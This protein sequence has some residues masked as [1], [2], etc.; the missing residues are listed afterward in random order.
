MASIS[1]YPTTGADC[2]ESFHNF[3]RKIIDSAKGIACDEL[4]VEHFE[5]INGKTS[6]HSL[7]IGK[8]DGAS[9]LWWN[10]SNYPNKKF[11]FP[12]GNHKGKVEVWFVKAQN[13]E[14]FTCG[15]LF[16]SYTPTD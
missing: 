7:V 1:R 11:T 15:D 2:R 3:L 9:P 10:L 13:A 8:T 5:T 16:F 6:R 12:D 14:H 4:S